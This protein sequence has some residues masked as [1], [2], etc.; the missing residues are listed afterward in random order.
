[1][2][3][4]GGCASHGS[5]KQVGLALSHAAL[6][7]VVGGPAGLLVKS[8][9]KSECIRLRKPCPQVGGAVAL[10]GDRH[11]AGGMTRGD[12]FIGVVPGVASHLD[13]QPP[14]PR[15]QL[16]HGARLSKEPADHRLLYLAQALVGHV[17]REL[18][19]QPDE[20]LGGPRL[21]TSGTHRHLHGRVALQGVG[22]GETLVHLPVG[23][24]QRDAQLGDHPAVL[25]CGG[26]DGAAPAL[27]DHAAPPTPEYQDRSPPS[28]PPRSPSEH[29]FELQRLSS[30]LATAS[31]AEIQ[32]D[33]PPHGVGL[34]RMG[35]G[36]I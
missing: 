23:K 11:P 16:S 6:V 4:Q 8:P 5:D 18:V 9:G 32:S 21:K 15:G 27:A 7:V 3:P 20:A 1:M 12:V 14:H 24:R 33:A 13:D 35:L 19:E 17:D 26:T 22:R 10:A 31:V 30:A 29:R 36:C 34:L 28:I 25:V 2:T